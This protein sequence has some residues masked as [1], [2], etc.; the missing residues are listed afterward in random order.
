MA[1]PGF[2]TYADPR[3]KTVEVSTLADSSLQNATMLSARING[4]RELFAT[5]QETFRALVAEWQRLR[6]SGS[7]TAPIMNDAYGQIVAM[8]WPVVRLLLNEVAKQSGQWF[9]ALTWI[10]REDL[11][12]PSTR[13]STRELR[14]AWL[15]WGNERGIINTTNLPRTMVQR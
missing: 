2:I 11:S 7:S 6:G 1:S 8:G 12:T 10:T 15:H 14:K 4:R 3:S 9:D 5:T 13:G